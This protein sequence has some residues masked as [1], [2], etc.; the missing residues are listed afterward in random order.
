MSAVTLLAETQWIDHAIETT[1]EHS[2]GSYDCSGC[3]LPGDE[4]GGTNEVVV[5]VANGVP[6]GYHGDLVFEIMPDQTVQ[7]RLDTK[8][9]YSDRPRKFP[10]GEKR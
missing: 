1:D 9:A 5:S 3:C 6:V 10:V 4:G 2:L 7:L 8:R